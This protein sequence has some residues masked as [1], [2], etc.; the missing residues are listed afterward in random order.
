MRI[1][2]EQKS[3]LD[4]TKKFIFKLDDGLISEVS[5]IDKGDGKSIYCMPSSTGCDMGCCFCHV[6]KFHHKIINRPLLDREILE[7]YKLASDA[8]GFCHETLLVSYMGMG[9]PLS[10]ITDVLRSMSLI[11][12]YAAKDYKSVRFALC[13]MFPL[14]HIKAF[15]ILVEHIYLSL[16]DIKLH[17]SIHYIGDLRNQMM[18]RSVPVESILDMLDCYISVTGRS[19]EIH[20]A[21]IEGVNDSIDDIDNLYF[22]IITYISDSRFS[23]FTVK[24]LQYNEDKGGYRKSRNPLKVLDYA[25]AFFPVKCELYS[26]PGQDIGASCGQFNSY[27][28]LKHNL[29]EGER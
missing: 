20:Y 23:K 2:E 6:T 29:K 21:L 25:K 15:D 5:Y 10:N 3:H 12:E 17:A 8:V 19:A 9:D 22:K 28:Y 4:H 27:Y 1:L 14:Q 11:K 18:P 7:M 16:Q 13:T 24:F 26:P